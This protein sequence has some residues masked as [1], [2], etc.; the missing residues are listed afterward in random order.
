MLPDGLPQLVDTLLRLPHLDTAQVSE[1]IQRL[2]DPLAYAQEMVRR[3]WITQNQFSS[4]FPR[5]QRQPTTRETKL[6]GFEDEDIWP[7]ADCNNWDLP[8]SDEEDT[9]DVPLEVDWARPDSIE[10]E[11]R[12][13]PETVEA[14]PV[15]SGPASTALCE[16]ETPPPVTAQDE[17]R[18]RESDMDTLLWESMVWTIK[19]LLV[20]AF[21][22]GS[23]FAGL[24]VF[25]AN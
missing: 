1:L 16:S 24:K 19:G 7:N 25:G 14:L 12:L 10:E 9:A 21:F 4:L 11:M 15:L 18:E 20:C 13:E 5:P 22:L 8:L 23:F 3:G 2:P 17:A 6:D